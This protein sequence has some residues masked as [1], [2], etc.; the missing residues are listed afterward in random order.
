MATKFKLTQQI[1]KK[2]GDDSTKNEG[3]LGQKDLTV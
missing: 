3:D 2:K 1:A